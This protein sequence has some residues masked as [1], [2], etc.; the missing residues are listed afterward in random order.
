MKIIGLTGSIASGK[1]TIAGWV[2]ELGIA[3]HDSDSV[4]HQLLG[5]AGEAVPDVLE[6]FGSHLGTIAGGI[7]RK[8]LFTEVFTASHRRKILESVLHPMV[9]HHRDAFIAVRRKADDAAV[10]LD[11]PLLFETGGDAICDYVI[12]AYASAK[13]TVARA[14]DRP[15]MTKDKLDLI[16]EAQMPADDKKIRADLV[17]DSDKSKDEMRKCLFDWLSGIGLSIVGDEYC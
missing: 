2:N 10:V 12:V 1:S 3:T 16:L 9:C 4:V 6:K 11:V 13:T 17:L 15:G 14:L 7:D 5:P 8:L